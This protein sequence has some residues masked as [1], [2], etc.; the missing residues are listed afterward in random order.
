MSRTGRLRKLGRTGGRGPPV[1]WLGVGLCLGMAL[2][3]QAAAAS[4]T[5]TAR[6]ASYAGGPSPAPAA[7]VLWQQDATVTNAAE[8][9]AGICVLNGTAK[10]ATVTYRIPD[11]SLTAGSTAAV[12]IVSSDPGT[13]A[14]LTGPRTAVMSVPSL[15]APA[16]GSAVA[17]FR[18]RVTGRGQAYDQTSIAG[19]LEYATAPNPG[20]VAFAD[21]QSQ[22]LNLTPLSTGPRPNATAATLSLTPP[23]RV[24]RAGKNAADSFR[25]DATSDG[26]AEVVVA[27]RSAAGPPCAATP[28]ADPG[29]KLFNRFFDGVLT[30]T[31]RQEL[32]KARGPQLLCGWVVQSSAPGAVLASASARFLIDEKPATVRLLPLKKRAFGVGRPFLLRAVVTSSAGAP[33]GRCVFEQRVGRRWRQGYTKTFRPP[34]LCGGTMRPARA[35]TVAFRVRYVPLDLGA[36]GP[37]TSPVRKLT[38][39]PRR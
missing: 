14:A 3:G 11:E 29:L 15:T 30:R 7:Y 34:K 16:A 12:Q 4:A 24:V 39:A 35:G 17:A 10:N 8:G 28:D 26:L 36:W 9:E 2:V 20:P 19:T 13:T 23:A 32:P 33:D 18:V 37:A 1:L 5:L 21:T 38:V 25:Y 6:C 22:L 31:Q 27:S